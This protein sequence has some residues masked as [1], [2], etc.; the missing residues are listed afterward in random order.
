MHI[1]DEFESSTINKMEQYTTI[2]DD[3]Q[4]STPT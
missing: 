2:T 4:K 3:I 1:M